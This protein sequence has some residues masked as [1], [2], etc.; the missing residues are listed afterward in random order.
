MQK[1][2]GI[3]PPFCSRFTSPWP[4]QIATT[5]SAAK[6]VKDAAL[7]LI[8]EDVRCQSAVRE[9]WHTLMRIL[10]DQATPV[11]IRSY[12]ASHHPTAAP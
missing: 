2:M 11:P 6:L 12:L 5:G 7:R 3:R 4:A 1:M 9:V 8:E 10:F